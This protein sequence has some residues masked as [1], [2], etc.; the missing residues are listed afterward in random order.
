MS[1]KNQRLVTSITFPVINYC[2]PHLSK[3]SAVESLL[4]K[5]DN[6]YYM[7][8]NFSQVTFNKGFTSHRDAAQ[9]VEKKHDTLTFVNSTQKH[10]N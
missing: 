6:L 3:I 5:L 7:Y 8:N 9:N 2:R 10:K 1:K 4:L